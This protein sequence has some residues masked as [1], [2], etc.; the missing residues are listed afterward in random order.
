MVGGSISRSSQVGSHARRTR[1]PGR[2]GP[3]RGHRP[4]QSKNK[5]G[6]GASIPPPPPSLQRQYGRI[7]GRDIRNPGEW[8]RD[9]E[10]RG[11][12]EAVK[13]LGRVMD[14]PTVPQRQPGF[15]PDV[16]EDPGYPEAQPADFRQREYGYD[17]YRSWAGRDRQQDKGAPQRVVYDTSWNTL[18]DNE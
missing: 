1:R 3:G 16:V 17:T 12:L 11:N 10:Q 13:A 2:Y 9:H 14:D 15:L 8:I 4:R 6:K 18:P 5:G 7:L